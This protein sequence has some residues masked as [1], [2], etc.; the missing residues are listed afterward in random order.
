MN[1]KTAN[2]IDKNCNHFI[3]S[4]ISRRT[5]FI[6]NTLIHSTLVQRGS[7]DIG[8]RARNG[9]QLKPFFGVHRTGFQNIAHLI[10]SS[11]CHWRLIDCLTDWLADLQGRDRNWLTGL[12]EGL[13]WKSPSGIH[14]QKWGCGGAA[15]P[16][17]GRPAP[18]VRLERQFWWFKFRSK[19]CHLANEFASA[20]TVRAQLV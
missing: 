10:S 17:W 16:T 4:C 5:V 9:F 3:R 7:A 2:I 1:N 15:P 19:Q 18:Q 8:V 13:G 11:T 6:N 12:R 14:G 20:Y